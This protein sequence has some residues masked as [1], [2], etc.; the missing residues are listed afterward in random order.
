MT[1]T[2]KTFVQDL[3]GSL[4]FV[5]GAFLAFSIAMF[6]LG[7]GATA[8]P[9][10]STRI[11]LAAI[12]LTGSVMGFVVGLSC[13]FLGGVLFFT[14][15]RV[16]L[17]RHGGGALGVLIGLTFIYGGF[18]TAGAG[19]LGATFT[20]LLGASALASIVSVVVGLFLVSATVWGAW[21]PHKSR[22]S[23]KLGESSPVS[24]A[25]REGDE[26]GVTTAEAAALLPVD[27][28]EEP[29]VPAHPIDVRL[30]GGV[31]EGTSAIRSK[32]PN[33]H[34]HEPET[35]QVDDASGGF[36]AGMETVQPEPA[37]GDLV[38]AGA[39]DI[40]AEATVESQSAVQASA[41]S[42]SDA[43]AVSPA[44]S[45][46]SPVVSFELERP[47]WEMDVIEEAVEEPQASID[48]VT[49]SVV[50]VVE[51]QGAAGSL[52]VEEA[53]AEVSVASDSESFIVKGEPEFDWG[54][55]EEESG[56]IASEEAEEEEEEQEPLAASENQAALDDEEEVGEQVEEDESEEAEEDEWEDEEYEEELDE[57]D[58]EA[59]Y[60][61]WEDE[62]DEVEEDEEEDGEE[63]E[64]E[65]EDEEEGELEQDELEEDENEEEE[66]LE[67]AELEEEPE[68]EADLS[69]AESRAAA[70]QVQSDDS[71]QTDSPE[72]AE[73]ESA[74]DESE[75]EPEFVV[76]PAAAKTK[77]PSRRARRD[78]RSKGQ[79]PDAGAE[80]E[81][82]LY[83]AG[84]KIIELDRVAVSMFQRDFD[85]PFQKATEILDE[86]QERG[87]IGPYLGGRHRD[88]LLTR[89]QWE[90]KA[91]SS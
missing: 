10:L 65:E 47:S 34:L 3:L 91:P 46:V 11:V 35:S 86:L 82:L 31:P 59:E 16:S 60:E 52:S 20:D 36:D 15:K 5:V 6:W 12:D 1:D 28:N 9:N 80:R 56:A 14:A 44:A 89:E 55:E 66:S 32:E 83:K 64:Y 70:E 30:K 62:E 19:L 67:A 78:A 21:L 23:S 26:G 22:F 54:G 57:E 41:E 73:P 24:A 81:L 84:L 42:G 29:I 40:E 4:L 50:E 17:L 48:E 45:A 53:E 68:E 74:G 38:E 51:E 72:A 77:R 25:L 43:S 87:L 76:K 85:L 49:E 58:P 13:A 7:D 2:K 79:V 75:S 33:E 69:Q 90:S 18:S 88:I 27:E 37:D 71:D 39:A 63:Y 61:E 8:N